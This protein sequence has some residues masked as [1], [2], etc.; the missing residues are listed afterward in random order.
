LETNQTRLKSS[1]FMK[2]LSNSAILTGALPLLG[3]IS[4]AAQVHAN[5]GVPLWTNR[6][7]GDV[8]GARIAVDT[9]GNVFVTGTSFEG[10]TTVAYSGGGLPL[11]TNHYS[12]NRRATASAVAV[13]RHGNVFV[14]GTIG[15]AFSFGD[16]NNLDYATVAFSGAGL[17]L[18]TNRYVGP[19]NL[20]DV[21]TA[22]AVDANGNVLVTGYSDQD[23][24][25]NRNYTTIKYSDTGVP[26]WTNS[27]GNGDATAL[28]VDQSGNV[29]VT[30][31]SIG[32]TVAYG[33]VAYSG[34]GVP[35]WTNR[36]LGPR[37]FG[38]ANRVVADAKGNVFVTGNS[39]SGY[40]TVGYSAAGLPLWTNFY[41]NGEAT[42]I[43]VDNNGN[44]FVTGF[45]PPV[46]P[47]VVPYG[48]VHSTV[49]YSG[50]GIPLWTN[51]YAGPRNPD[52]GLTSIAVD[53]S[54]NVFVTGAS[55]NSIYYQSYTTVAYTGTGIPLWTNLYTGPGNTTPTAIA[56]DDNGNVFV[57]GTSS[58]DYATIKYS[59]INTPPVVVCPTNSTV[60]CGTPAVLTASV[61]DIDG[62]SLSVGWSLNGVLVQTNTVAQGSSM[63]GT[64]LSLSAV[65]L[66]GTNTL[67]INVAD[68]A[69]SSDSFSTTILAVDT[70]PPVIDSVTAAPDVL[71]PPDLGMVPIQLDAVVTDTCGP[72]DW[73]IIAV[74]SN[75]PSDSSSDWKIIGDHELTLRAERSGQ[76][77]GRLYT[78]TIQATDLS[79]N[80]SESSTTVLVPHDKKNTRP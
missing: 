64:N 12:E 5:G 75:E 61:S 28:T 55:S 65:L 14:T 77:N 1:G 69:G 9:G 79:G 47:G 56:V 27:Y 6:F 67:T 7:A 63:T 21:A 49:A 48:H 3:I 44:V 76:G 41:G 17:P 33:T 74:S 45:S 36:F 35:L 46:S 42:D 51:R 62:D 13:D 39:G 26:L 19:A 68:T 60:E 24:R 29:F 37:G 57:T 8:G 38:I 25:G 43:A 66:L 18:W 4:P 15:A 54:G 80:V 32:P 16:T 53:R 59:A 58:S 10:F 52:S 22:I 72:V 2:I 11:W 70:T 40:G 23:R 31:L 78:I 20:D 30:G 73:K 34:A 71:W 50:T